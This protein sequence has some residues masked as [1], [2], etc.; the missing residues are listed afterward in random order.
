MRR[1]RFVVSVVVVLVLAATMAA[2]PTFAEEN[3]R[4]GTKD[5]FG[6]VTSQKAS[7]TP[8][9]N[10]DTVGKH[11][12][13]QDEPRRGVGNVAREDQGG[14]PG[15]HGCFIGSVDNDPNTNCED[16]PGK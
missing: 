15:D 12:S 10:T 13:S 6:A 11:A 8:H 1:I 7:E 14:K 9:D 5:G 16:K 4:S 3:G 2:L